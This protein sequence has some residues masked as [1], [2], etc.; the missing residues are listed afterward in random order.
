[1]SL[2]LT[3]L[4]QDSLIALYELDLNPIGENT[5]VRFCNWI[6][7]ANQ[8]VEF[9]G[10]D[11]QAF[12]IKAEGFESNTNGQLPTP[13]ITISN[14]FREMTAFALS[15]DDLVGAKVTRIRTLAKHLDNGDD[16]DTTAVLPPD[17]YFVERKVNEN[18]LF[19]QFELS[20][21]LDLGEYQLPSRPMVA[22]LCVWTYRG[23]ECGYAGGAVAD[24]DGNP[25][26]QMSQDKCGKKV[27]DCKLRFGQN[28][29]LNF[30]G[31]PG[32]DLVQR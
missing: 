7:E 28:G 6:D 27:S 29:V 23:P 15:Y 21:S 2:E 8:V 14:V 5:I 16:P 3:G 30:G 18:K 12:P 24:E 10:Q 9:D 19:V 22:N 13:Q 20:A 32:L 1:M 11:Y 26:G 4:T 31:Y 25:T 17:I